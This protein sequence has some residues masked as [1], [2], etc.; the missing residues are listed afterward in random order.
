MDEATLR[1]LYLKDNLSTAG[2]AR[3]F[4]VS[5]HKVNYWISKY[6]IPKRS[7]SQAVYLKR[8]PKG[9]PFKYIKPK[10]ESELVLFGLGIGLFWGEG[11]KV[12]K[13]SVRLGNTDPRLIEMFLKFLKEIY[14]I[15]NKKLR[16]GLQIFSDTKP[17]AAKKFWIERLRVRPDQFQKI[18]V[19]PSRGLG[20]YKHK[21]KYG[22]LTINFSNTK[23]KGIMDKLIENPTLM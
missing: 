9:D 12:S 3:K 18:V 17:A 5:E 20:T 8:N 16:F 11:N 4:S 21:S 1:R 6:Q 15:D 14:N 10:T 13:N 19:T 23:L 7:I 22:V 2:I